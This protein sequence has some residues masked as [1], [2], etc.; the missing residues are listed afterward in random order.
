MTGARGVTPV[1]PPGGQWVYESGTSLKTPHGTMHG[2]TP[3]LDD[4]GVASALLE[5]LLPWSQIFVVGQSLGRLVLR[6]R[7]PVRDFEE[8]PKAP[9]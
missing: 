9:A 8:Q 4:V 1:L 3:A 5:S 2:S 7:L 6:T